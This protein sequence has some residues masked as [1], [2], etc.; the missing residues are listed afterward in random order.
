MSKIERVAPAGGALGF[1]PGG[2]G[3]PSLSSRLTPYAVGVALSAVDC[4]NGG[5]CA[6]DELVPPG[7]KFQNTPKPPRT[8]VLP[9]PE[10]SYAKPSRGPMS[11]FEYVCSRRPT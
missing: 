1:T 5:F 8:S 2:F 3:R 4:R 10:I 6:F 7:E 11:R 9:S